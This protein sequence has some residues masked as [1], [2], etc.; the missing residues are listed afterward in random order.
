MKGRIAKIQYDIR[1]SIGQH[2]IHDRLLE[3]TGRRE[4]PVAM[5]VRGELGA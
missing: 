2:A 1:T 5:N 4:L 3:R